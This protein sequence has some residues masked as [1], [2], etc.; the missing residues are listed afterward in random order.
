MLCRRILQFVLEATEPASASR[1]TTVGPSSHLFGGY[2]G[3]FPGG[4]EAEA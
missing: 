2:R 3:S 4:I 1:L